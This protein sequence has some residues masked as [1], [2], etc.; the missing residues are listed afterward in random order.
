[1]DDDDPSGYNDQRARSRAKCRKRLA[2]H[3]SKDPP[4]PEWVF[5]HAYLNG[6]ETLNLDI[7]PADVRL[8]ASSELPYAWK[9]D[10]P[11]LNP[12]FEKHLSKHSCK[13]YL[14]LAKEVGESF[15]AVSTAGGQL[16]KT[17]IQLQNDLQAAQTQASFEKIQRLD[18]ENELVNLRIL[19]QE[20]QTTIELLTQENQQ[21]SDMVQQYQLCAGQCW[22]QLVQTVLQLGTIQ[23]QV[24][25]KID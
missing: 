16:D 6:D 11:D 18:T 15:H 9:V 2:K 12:L 23:A 3:I 22:D 24:P 19:N 17:Y 21:L 7:Q 20:A 13:T 8:K 14:L 4:A 25:V 5:S 10:N 1:M